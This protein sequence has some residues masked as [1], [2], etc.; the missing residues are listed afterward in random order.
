MSASR[1]I[2]TEASISL[3]L[4]GGLLTVMYIDGTFE[5]AALSAI[6]A[7]IAG[8]GLVV[9]GVVYITGSVVKK[10]VE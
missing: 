10:A 7:W 6:L 5:G 2:F 4:V 9:S 8:I 1:K 3:V